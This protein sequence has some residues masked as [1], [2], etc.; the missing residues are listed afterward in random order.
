[1]H[2]VTIFDGFGKNIKS[3]DSWSMWPVRLF[4]LEMSLVYMGAALS[5]INSRS[6]AEGTAMYYISY[7]QDYYPGVVNPD[8][9]FN[10][11]LPLKLFCWSAMC[12]EVAG[13]T[14]VWVP[15]TRFWAVMGMFAL[16]I[17]IDLTMNMYAF[18][19]LAMIGWAIYLVQPTATTSSS[20]AAA[21]TVEKDKKETKLSTTPE[22]ETSSRRGRR[23]GNFI[24]VTLLS[25]FAIDALPVE[26]MEILAPKFL[27]PWLGALEE[28][29]AD[30]YEV[31]QPMIY[32]AGLQQGVWNMYTGDYPDSS[33]CY[34]QAELFYKNGTVTEWN[35]PD[36]M[37]MTWWQRKMKM[38]LM[39]YYD[40]GESAVAAASWVAFAKHLQKKYSD[41]GEN[42]VGNVDMKLRCE[43]GV[44]LPED[45]GWFE[46]VRQ[47]MEEWMQPMVILDIC[48][49][50]YEDECGYWK[51]QGMC[52]SYKGGMMLYCQQ[53]CGFCKDYIVTWPTQVRVCR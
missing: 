5:K 13:F 3:D 31:I 44:E 50:D 11:L 53:T 12:L 24:L 16:H 8:F 49:D 51:E 29:R 40:S 9:L 22:E 4:Q 30:V 19:W 23:I 20:V 14:L 26:D 25:V 28:N 37:E 38:R 1:M 27:K 36:W 47:P 17:G 42:V 7:T 34:Y 48:A 21:A 6:W 39:N 15:W 10:R 43:G 41:G 52:E 2:T 32:R 45:I 33:N 35:S 18:E 46:P